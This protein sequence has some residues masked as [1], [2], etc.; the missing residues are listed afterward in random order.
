MHFVSTAPDS[1]RESSQFRPRHVPREFVSCFSYHTYKHADGTTLVRKVPWGS[2]RQVVW[3]RETAYI[4]AKKAQF[5]LQKLEREWVPARENY[6]TEKLLAKR[7]V[8]SFGWT[9]VHMHLCLPCLPS[10][11][12]NQHLYS[13]TTQ[14]SLPRKLVA[15]KRG[16]KSAQKLFVYFSPFCS[17]LAKI[18]FNQKMAQQDKS[19][20]FNKWGFLDDFFIVLMNKN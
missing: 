15:I 3:N 17:N 11:N 14:I 12:H 10:S 19:H 5:S 7:C 16:R 13:Q 20:C 1:F 2:I 18:S 4:P 9:T 6:G 8:G